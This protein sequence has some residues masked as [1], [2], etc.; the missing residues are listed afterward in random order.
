MS[1]LHWERK[2]AGFYE[3][4]FYSNKYRYRIIKDVN[5]NNWRSYYIW[6]NATE[7]KWVRLRTWAGTSETLKEAKE[8]CRKHNERP[9]NKWKLM[10]KVV[11]EHH[12]NFGHYIYQE[13]DRR[14]EPYKY[15]NYFLDP[16]SY[17][18]EIDDDN[19]KGEV[20]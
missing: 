8:M 4:M 20:A 19:E 18:T 14:G 1:D 3:T 15:R 16:A 9:R 17:S 13:L 7:K 5:Y 6:F 10:G 12:K 2:E 11:E